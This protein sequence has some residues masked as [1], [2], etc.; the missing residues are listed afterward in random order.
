MGSGPPSRLCIQC[1][2]N[3]SIPSIITI[4]LLLFPSSSINVPS[5]QG[6]EHIWR[7]KVILEQALGNKQLNKTYVRSTTQ[8]VSSVILKQVT[9]KSKIDK[10]FKNI[11][12]FTLETFGPFKVKYLSTIHNLYTNLGMGR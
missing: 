3:T 9:K 6:K 4:D 12:L 2:D 11:Y 5:Y 7:Y 8:K 1:L 10:V